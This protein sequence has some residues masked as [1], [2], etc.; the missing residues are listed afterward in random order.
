MGCAAISAALCGVLRRGSCCALQALLPRPA[1]GA[2][3]AAARPTGVRHR[4]GWDLILRAPLVRDAGRAGAAVSAMV[5]L[6]LHEFNG[7]ESAHLLQFR[8]V[9]DEPR[10]LLAVLREGQS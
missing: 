2:A 10:A 9:F 5:G 6:A 3:A 4:V 8:I 1:F 7:T